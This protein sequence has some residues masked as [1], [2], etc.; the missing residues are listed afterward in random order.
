MEQKQT[1]IR[2]PVRLKER[3]QQEAEKV[4]VYGN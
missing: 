2:L 4:T 1:A 3:L